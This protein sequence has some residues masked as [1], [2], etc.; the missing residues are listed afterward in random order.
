L[1]K[2][3]ILGSELKLVSYQEQPVQRALRDLV[4][5]TW[6]DRPSQA[7]H[8]VLP[9]A[10]ID[11]VW[12][13]YALQVA[14][15]D[16]GPLPLETQPTF[17]GIRFRPGAA[18]GVLVVPA[19]ELL[20]R[21]VSLRELWG[22]LADTLADRLATAPAEAPRLLESTVLSR[23]AADGFS[24]DPLIPHVLRRLSRGEGVDSLPERLG[25]SQRTLRRRCVSAIGYGPKTLERVLRFRRALGLIRGRVPLAEIAGL[26]GYADQAHLTNEFQRLAGNTPGHLARLP[27]VPISSNGLR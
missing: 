12:D 19:S 26:A 24:S 14:G 6:V 1:K 11:I 17:V 27:N 13:G 15:P 25:V 9:D 5:C 2:T 23:L 4:V 22:P 3:A 18:P 10:C 16:T 7:R 8:P 20:D 21:S